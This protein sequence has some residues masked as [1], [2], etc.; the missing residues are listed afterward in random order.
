LEFTEKSI[1]PCQVAAHKVN[2]FK[3]SPLPIRVTES[4]N[5]G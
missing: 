1:S 3:W 2:S 5:E 4:S